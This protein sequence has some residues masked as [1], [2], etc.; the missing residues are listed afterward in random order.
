M[1]SKLFT[2]LNALFVVVLSTSWAVYAQNELTRSVTVD[3]IQ[4][5]LL[6]YLPQD[7]QPSEAHQAAWLPKY[8]L[9]DILLAGQVCQSTIEFCFVCLRDDL[10]R[11]RRTLGTLGSR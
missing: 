3:G 2:R 11:K 5:Q 1:A 8:V 6:V 4:R 9:R 7:F 10:G